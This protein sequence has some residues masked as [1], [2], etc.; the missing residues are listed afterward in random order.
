MASVLMGLGPVSP[1]VQ[2]DQIILFYCPLPNVDTPGF[3]TL[4]RD[5]QYTW[6]SQDRL[7]RDPAMQFTGPGEDSFVVEG[8]M[9]PHHFGGL[10]TIARLRNAGRAGKPH[11]LAR[12]YPL[13]NPKGG[14][15]EVIGNFVIKRV[16]TVETKVGRQGIAHKIDF[17]LELT[18]YGDDDA[19]QARPGDG[20]V[21]LFPD[22]AVT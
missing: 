21:V 17:V 15:A 6:T 19:G 1:N 11:I 22:Q 4:Q 8:R 2:E 16:K 7:S 10:S 5:S 9:F 12:F 20:G 3:E 13:E 14:G 18:R